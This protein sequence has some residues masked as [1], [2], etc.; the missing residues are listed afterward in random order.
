M[1][2]IHDLLTSYLEDTDDVFISNLTNV[3]DVDGVDDYGETLLFK[4]LNERLDYSMK[5]RALLEHGADPN[6]TTRYTNDSIITPLGLA[7]TGKSWNNCFTCV[8]TTKILLECGAN[9]NQST[10]H[11]GSP[12]QCS[13]SFYYHRHD[14]NELFLL[15]RY[16]ATEYEKE[17]GIF[18]SVIHMTF[19]V[20]D[21]MLYTDDDVHPDWIRKIK[22]RLY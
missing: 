15:L 17:Y 1:I 16:G 12:L 11:Y 9:P 18:I 20:C 13:M 21:M 3:D 10:G 14:I 22:E 2:T 6:Q 4:C 7:I 19:I 8:G 5:I